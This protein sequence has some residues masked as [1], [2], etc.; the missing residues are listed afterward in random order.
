M[1][2][3]SSSS[4]CNL[5]A[6]D[7]SQSVSPSFTSCI[8]IAGIVFFAGDFRRLQHR[9]FPLGNRANQFVLHSQPANPKLSAASLKTQ[10]LSSEDLTVALNMFA[11]T[12]DGGIGRR[13]G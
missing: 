10:T 11:A 9:I 8:E 5:N 2:R 4:R 3:F 6:P 7:L 1:R 12:G 13:R